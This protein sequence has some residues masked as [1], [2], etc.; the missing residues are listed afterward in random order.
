M[1]FFK[2][3]IGDD[4][5]CRDRELKD[6]LDRYYGKE[7]DWDGEYQDRAIFAVKDAEKLRARMIEIL[8][9]GYSRHTSFP[10]FDIPD[11]KTFA[12]LMRKMLDN[13][14]E[15]SGKSVCV[16]GYIA[17]SSRSYYHWQKWSRKNAGAVIYPF[18]CKTETEKIINLILMDDVPAT[19]SIS[20]VSDDPFPLI[21]GLHIRALGEIY[22]FVNGADDAGIGILAKKVEVLD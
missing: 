10:G 1:A 3:K 11:Y 21:E 20:V 12:S 4:I 19:T 8:N 5:L 9:D 16:E 14:E 7:P 13:P 22:V 2:K 18:P 6:L 17:W 15:Y